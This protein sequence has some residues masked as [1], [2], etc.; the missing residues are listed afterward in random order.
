MKAAMPKPSFGLPASPMTEALWFHMRGFGTASDKWPKADQISKAY[1]SDAAPAFRPPKPPIELPLETKPIRDADKLMM[2]KQASY[3]APA[4]IIASFMTE[5]ESSAV[6]P[7]REALLVTTDPLARERLTQVIEH[8]Q[9]RTSTQLGYALRSLAASYNVLASQRK[10]TLVKLQSQDL[11]R[12]LVGEK[13]GFKKFFANEIGPITQLASASAQL[14]LTHAALSRFS[15]NRGGKN[16]QNNQ[17]QKPGGQNNNGQNNKN[18]TNQNNRGRRWRRWWSQAQW[19][20]R[21][22][23]TGQGC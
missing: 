20:A 13:L 16:N 9:G 15:G 17:K 3:S 19:G 2:K 12:V 21:R 4:H 11:Q 1:T 18:T 23:W 7:L 8:L 5:L 6:I 10:D 14:R 22:T